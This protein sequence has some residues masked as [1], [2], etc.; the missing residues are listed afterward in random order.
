MKHWATSEPLNPGP[1]PDRALAWS[2][3]N[4]IFSWI[5]QRSQDRLRTS[6]IAI[7]KVAHRLPKRVQTKI[8]TSLSAIHPIQERCEF[9]QLAPS[10]HEIKV[11]YLLS[12]HA[13]SLNQ[14]L[15]RSKL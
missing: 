5:A 3:S 8:R 9:D 10:I 7:S 11:Q 12:S 4:R 15:N 13:R 1:S 6:G 14:S 2:L